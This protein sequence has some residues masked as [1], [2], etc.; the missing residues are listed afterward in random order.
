MARPR[1]ADNERR[2]EPLYIRMSPDEIAHIEAQ[3]EKAGLDRVTFARDYL[4]G[5]DIKPLPA[6]AR[7]EKTDAGKVLL[8]LDRFALATKR[9]LNAIGNNIN[10]LVK[11]WHSGLPTYPA[12]WQAAH[13]ELKA[14]LANLNSALDTVGSAYDRSGS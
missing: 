2:S 10:Q 14:T 12:D 5:A 1:K 11:D 8:A 4:L 6:T 7:S 3:A 9:E 13:D